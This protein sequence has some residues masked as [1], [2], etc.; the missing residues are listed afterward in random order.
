MG[1]PYVSQALQAH[2]YDNDDDDNDEEGNYNYIIDG[3]E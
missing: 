1:S 2:T 3:Y